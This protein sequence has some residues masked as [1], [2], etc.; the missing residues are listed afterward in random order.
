MF[1]FSVQRAYVAAV[2]HAA[3]TLDR[4]VLGVIEDPEKRR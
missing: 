1:D 4:E 2:A 3:P